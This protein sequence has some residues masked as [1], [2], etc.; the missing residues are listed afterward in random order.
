MRM[1]RAHSD[2]GMRAGLVGLDG[3]RVQAFGGNGHGSCVLGLWGC[4][5]L[6]PDAGIGLPGPQGLVLGERT[7]SAQQE[8]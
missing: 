7:L 4:N 2:G 6:C 1:G 3:V 8:T 5:C